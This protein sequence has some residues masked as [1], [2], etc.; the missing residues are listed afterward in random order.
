VEL[1]EDKL[2]MSVRNREVLEL[3]KYHLNMVM[4]FLA[5]ATIIIAL[6]TLIA[7]IYGMNLKL[8]FRGHP[9]AFFITMGAAL[10]VSLVVLV[11]FIRKDWL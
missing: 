9:Q 7:S 4:K 2:Q 8:P 1:L 5:P 10:L 6:P 11:V 3:L